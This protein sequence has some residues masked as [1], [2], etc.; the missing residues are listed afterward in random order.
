M[1]SAGYFW[2]G[3]HLGFGRHAIY[4]AEEGGVGGNRAREL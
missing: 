2:V 4:S 1:Y 3:G